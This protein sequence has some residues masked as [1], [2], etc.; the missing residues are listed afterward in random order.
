MKELLRFDNVLWEKIGNKIL[1]PICPIHR[2][3]MDQWIIEGQ[4]KDENLLKCP[5]CED[6]LELPRT[7]DD[8]V[9]YIERKLNS[10]DYK[11][12]KILNLDD[13]QIPVAEDE[14]PSPKD[15]KYFVVARLMKSKVGLRLVV[16]AGEKGAKKKTQIFVEPQIKRLAFDQKDMHP[17]EVFTMLEATFEDGSKQSIQKPKAQKTK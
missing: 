2:M 13:E 16:Y 12:L 4:E 10:K 6:M 17:S 1:D 14:V 8:E 15:S 3:K 9:E 11:H 5:D 7:W